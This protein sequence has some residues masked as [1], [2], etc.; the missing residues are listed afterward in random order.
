MN[1]SFQL[2][3]YDTPD[4]LSLQEMVE[5]DSREM[6]FNLNDPLFQLHEQGIF[7]DIHQQ[8]MAVK[9]ERP[10]TECTGTGDLTNLQWLQ[11][12]SIPME[13]GSNGE[14]QVMVDPNTA[15][16]VQWPN[17]QAVS[18]SQVHT[19]VNVT[20]V[21]APPILQ[22]RATDSK[23]KVQQQNAK[24]GMK[25]SLKS[26]EKSYPKPLFSY[27][28]LI[29]MA[30]KNSDSGTLPVSEI[31]KFM[32]GK[33][34]YF[35]T[36]PDGWK[37]SVRH[38]LSLNKAFCKLE[39]PQGASQR[40]GCLW[41][42]KPERREQMDKEIR[43]WKKKHAEAI[44]ASM[45]NPEELSISSDDLD[46]SPEQMLIQSE[47]CEDIAAADAAK[48]LF[49]NDLIHEIQQNEVLDWDDIISQSTELPID[50]TLS[51]CTSLPM[52][53]QPINGMHGCDP[54]TTTVEM[55]NSAQYFVNSDGQDFDLP[56]PYVSH[57]YSMPQPQQHINVGF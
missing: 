50:P 42:L 49:G 57:Y 24:N 13:K 18:M 25:D 12:V 16:P 11:S 39:R 47:H 45:A 28:C 21:P 35:K 3:F 4:S 5:C 54:I 31:Y 44:R 1:S 9:Q 33:F 27:S 41:S 15:L 48:E 20:A 30:L 17:H 55:E 52:S 29:A 19:Q 32:M 46:N 26:Q 14:K 36:A 34:P 23:P 56:L 8:M 6:D 43:K 37:N 51:T 22:A 7:Q 53:T 10:R 38:N 2:A 40:K